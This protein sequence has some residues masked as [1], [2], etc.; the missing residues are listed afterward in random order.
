[1]NVKIK[2]NESTWKDLVLREDFFTSKSA[3]FVGDKYLG[4]VGYKVDAE[5][6]GVVGNV[7][8]KQADGWHK[9]VSSWGNLSDWQDMKLKY[10]DGMSLQNLV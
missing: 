2:V 9:L 6:V 1:M 5:D 10:F 7:Y 3:M 8:V 4:L